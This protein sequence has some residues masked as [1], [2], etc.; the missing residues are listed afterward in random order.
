IEMTT[1]TTIRP[2]GAPML[3]IY[4]SASEK[5]GTNNY[6]SVGAQCGLEIEL[7]GRLADDAGAL[8]EA[9]TRYQ[10]IATTA[11]REH[12]GRMTSTAGRPNGPH[13][14]AIAAPTTPAPTNGK[15]TNGKGQTSS[16]QP[17]ARTGKAST[18]APEPDPE[19]VEFDEQE[20]TFTAEDD[21]DDDTPTTGRE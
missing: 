12:L 3:K 17:P 20:E 1:T 8:H 14:T 21:R 19:F 11:M 7:D 5:I 9:I 15:P 4:V 18:P 10:Q 16:E 2:T 6:G 13:A